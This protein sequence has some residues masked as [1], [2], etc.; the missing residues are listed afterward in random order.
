[1]LLDASRDDAH[2]DLEYILR[3]PRHEDPFDYAVESGDE[4]GDACTE[5]DIPARVRAMAEREM[6]TAQH[7]PGKEQDQR[8]QRSEER[9]VGTECVST[10][11]SRW[12]PYHLKKKKT[13]EVRVVH[14]YINN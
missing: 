3:G 7:R 13:N 14:R 9:R 8:G 12:S 4:Y 1:M 11:R 10:G 5:H 6:Q 2:R